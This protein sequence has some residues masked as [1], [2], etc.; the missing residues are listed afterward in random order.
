M[1]HQKP[2]NRKCRKCGKRFT[3]LA[4]LARKKACIYCSFECALEARRKPK[5]K[6]RC[7]WCKKPIIL[8]PWQTKRAAKY[9]HFCNSKCYGQWRSAE[10]AGENS[11]NWK[12]GVSGDR[13]C[14]HWKTMRFKARK[15][16]GNRCQKCGVK[17]RSARSLDVHHIKPYDMFDDPRKANSL[18]N[19]IT[20]CRKCHCHE[21]Q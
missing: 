11:P 14:L 20:L 4:H 5:T 6:V 10:L 3:R 9:G 18:R 17:S 8:S 15:R 21:H 2:I 13:G 1:T 7:D 16:D 12:N 19:L